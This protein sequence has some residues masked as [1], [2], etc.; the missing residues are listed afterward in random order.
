MSDIPQFQ[1]DVTTLG[2]GLPGRRR[3]KRGKSYN[4][5]G[6]GPREAFGSR[7]I[8]RNDDFFL[9]V[10]EDGSPNV[11]RRKT[12]EAPGWTRRVWA[13]RAWTGRVRTGRYGR[14]VCG[15]DGDGEGRSKE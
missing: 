15:R 3:V 13:G 6:S 10:G 12:L 1:D 7:L 8:H 11:R 4:R 14:D 2:E 5:S 9:G